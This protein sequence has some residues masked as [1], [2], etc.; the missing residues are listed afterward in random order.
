MSTESGPLK[1]AREQT[2]QELTA[3]EL[4][5]IAGGSA[6]ISIKFSPEHT[7]MAAAGC[8]SET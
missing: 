2:D 6:G 3:G 1:Q 4:E 5:R 8:M 7:R